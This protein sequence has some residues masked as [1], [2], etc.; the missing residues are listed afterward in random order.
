MGGEVTYEELNKLKQERQL[1]VLNNASFSETAQAGFLGAGQT[2]SFMQPYVIAGLS[3]SP[4]IAELAKALAVAQNK[5]KP[6]VK[7]T[8]NPYFHSKY[9]DLHSLIE[10]TRSALAAEGLVITQG[11]E[12]TEQ[13]V[14]ITT[15]LLHSSGQWMQ[16]KLSLPATSM[17]KDSKIKFDAQ[18]VGSAITYARRYA[19]QAILNIAADEDDDG[20]SASG[21]VKPKVPYKPKPEY[22]SFSHE[23]EAEMAE[24]ATTLH[25]KAPSTTFPSGTPVGKSQTSGVPKAIIPP[26]LSPETEQGEFPT[27][28][29]RTA[30][31][32]RL[33]YYMKNLLPKAGVENPEE[34]MQ[35]FV[36]RFTGLDNT[37]NYTKEVW[38]KLLAA[39][40]AAKE[41]GKLGDLVTG[42]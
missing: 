24:G 28:E 25:P 9:V 22:S 34:T 8:E 3:W 1:E 35:T 20:N 29:E 7:D 38:N 30:N 13:E 31:L 42:G 15:L 4:Q 36:K 6:V 27:A 12:R 32:N 21:N 18:S 14:T 19:Y 41:T 11:A 5:F 16:N 23:A 10:S 39:L 40:D 2:Q 37:K 33:R 17:G 26:E